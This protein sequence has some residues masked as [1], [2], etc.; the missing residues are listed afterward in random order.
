[1]LRGGRI[2][3]LIIPQQGS[4]TFELKVPRVIVA[5]AVALILIVAALLGLGVHAYFEA[6]VLRHLVTDLK[7][8]KELLEEQIEQIDQLE[9]VLRRVQKSNRQLHAILGESVGL[10]SRPER[11]RVLPD[12]QLYI[13]SVERLRLGRVRGLPTLWPA[14][15]VV[16][17]EFSDELPAVLIAV[18]LRSL[19]RA[20]GPGWVVAAGFD[21]E[22]GY[23]VTLD[24]G[25]GLLTQYGYN[26]SLLVE[27]G[28]YV[29]K[30][31][32]IALSGATGKAPSHCLYFAVEED[33]MPQDPQYLRLWL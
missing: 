19:V 15:G 3:L 18:P 16:A 5:L 32:A 4:K 17:R 21:A 22:L 2:N 14:R 29:H 23:A 9:R 12:D 20:S 33:G 31:Q 11:S 10:E 28:D 7:R 6:R 8:D 27:A 25:H 1:M 30:G 26:G 13:P 24:H